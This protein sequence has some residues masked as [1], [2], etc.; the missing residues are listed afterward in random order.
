MASTRNPRFPDAEVPADAA[1]TAVDPSRTGEA[2]S[3]PAAATAGQPGSAVAGE[4]I[5]FAGLSGS[6][7]GRNDDRWRVADDIGLLLLA[8]GV[9][10]YPAGDV[11]AELAVETACELI[12]D[13]LRHGLTPAQALARAMAVCNDEI[14]EI[15]AGRLDFHGMATTLVCALVKDGCLHLAHVGDS[16]GYLLRDGRLIRLTRDH[17][18]GQQIIETGRLTA[19]E[20]AGL[21][22][23]GILTR[24][25]GL[26]DQV[27]PDL[28]VTV[29][30]PDDTLLLCSDGL[31]T[32]LADPVLEHLLL[33]AAGLG[34]A[35]QA[36]ALVGGALQTAI[37]VNVTALVATPADRQGP[38]ADLDRPH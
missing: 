34:P 14:R 32:A 16:R 30:R 22:A 9:S 8:D 35:G 25:L 7:R 6:V 10:G 2:A 24:A 21:P 1:G 11:A 28:G 17:C 5:Q 31:T 26:A 23:R 20:V 4:A 36:R 33:S 13:L 19:A 29:W 27:E 18:V 15:A 37:P 38:G 12:P 3:F